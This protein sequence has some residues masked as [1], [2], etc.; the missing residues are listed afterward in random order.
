MREQST[1]EGTVKDASG[2][3]VPLRAYAQP[4]DAVP[5]VVQFSVAPLNVPLAVPTTG[6]PAHV[7]E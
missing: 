7:V 2:V 6:T 5:V 1:I 3:A 4:F